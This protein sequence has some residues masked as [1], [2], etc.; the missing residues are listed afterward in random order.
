MKLEP[1]LKEQYKLLHHSPRLYAKAIQ[2][3][4]RAKMSNNMFREEEALKKLSTLIGDSNVLANLLGRR[5]AL[6]EFE[7]YKKRAQPYRK[8]FL[9]AEGDTPVIPTVT[10]EMAVQDLVTRP[11]YGDQLKLG[12]M[13]AQRLYIGE[14]AFAL[15]KTTDAVL[16]KKVQALIVRSME[17]GED[18]IDAS[19][20]VAELGDFTEAYA[21][22][23][24]RTNLTQSY[25]SGRFQEANDPEIAE[26]IG[27]MMYS[28]LLDPVTRVNHK[29]AEGL[30]AGTNDPIWNNL[31]PPLGFNC[32]CTVVMMDKFTLDEYGLI[33]PRGEVSRGWKLSSGVVTKVPPAEFALAGPDARFI[34]G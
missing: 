6:L 22:T 4:L 8:A 3:L 24:Y 30:I 12:W 13:E 23:V 27:G 21:E 16:T 18:M 2:E 33:S 26:V 15:A 17:E 20:A 31:K 10:Y 1:A 14:H 5:R 32:R 19:Q 9:F 11:V 28:A 25:V 7:Q 34:A 29:A